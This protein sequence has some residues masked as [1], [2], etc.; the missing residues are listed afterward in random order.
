MLN[1]TPVEGRR[2]IEEFIRLP[3]RLSAADP[4]WVEPL[5]FER[6][7]F[8]SPRKNPFF[9]HAEVALWLARRGGDAGGPPVGR[10]SAQIDSLAPEVDGL[11]L[12]YFGMLA[13]ENDPETL[14]A[15]FPEIV[16]DDVIARGRAEMS[17]SKPG[18][19]AL[20]FHWLGDGVWMTFDEW[21]RIMYANNPADEELR[22]KYIVDKPDMF[23][24]L[25]SA[26]TSTSE[27]DTN[28]VCTPQSDTGDDTPLP[29]KSPL[30]VEHQPKVIS[31]GRG[32]RDQ[33]MPWC[34]RV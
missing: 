11:K 6:R 10:I 9:E 26:S 14:A 23:L 27:P 17:P 28:A 5:W 18:V 7:D 31:G 34:E 21:S 20:V 15:L 16:P 24:D 33:R 22:Q 8:L 25:E 19:Y 2:Q 29:D 32:R 3:G 13:S 4:N 1:V 12:G 30:V